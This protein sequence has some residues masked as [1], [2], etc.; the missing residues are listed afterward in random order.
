M[1]RAGRVLGIHE[2]CL[3]T[4]RR[5]VQKK[6]WCTNPLIVTLSQKL[7]TCFSSCRIQEEPTLL[8]MVAFMGASL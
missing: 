7:E 4:E 5:L 2:L 3:F 6:N 8:L 1:C